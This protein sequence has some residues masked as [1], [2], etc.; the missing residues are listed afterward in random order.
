MTFLESLPHF[1]CKYW[2]FNGSYG[3]FRTLAW[4]LA[5]FWG[6]R[7]LGKNTLMF[8][9]YDELQNFLTHVENL[10][11][12]QILKKL[13]FIVVVWCVVVKCEECDGEMCWQVNTCQYSRRVYCF[14]G[15]IMLFTKHA[16]FKTT[17]NV[18]SFKWRSS[19]WNRSCWKFGNFLVCMWIFSE[20]IFLRVKNFDAGIAGTLS[21]TASL[22]YCRYVCRFACMTPQ[23]S[24][25]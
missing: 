20:Q 13:S 1:W 19:R 16:I 14:F 12:N 17:M 3:C 15:R 24:G 7:V 22:I 21:F 5:S 9:I 10:F 4:V 2:W 8:R 18:L 6:F 25:S 11:L 23:L